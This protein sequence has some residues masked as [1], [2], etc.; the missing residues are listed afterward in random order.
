MKSD[1]RADSLAQVV[2]HVTQ[3]WDQEFKPHIG[4]KDLKIGSL[5]K[6]LTPINYLKVVIITI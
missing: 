5:K 2:E 3:S 4:Y 6:S 1:P